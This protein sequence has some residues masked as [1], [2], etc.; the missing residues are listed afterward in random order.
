MYS[1]ALRRVV[2]CL[3]RTNPNERPTATG[4]LK[5]QDIISK[6]HHDE[7]HICRTGISN[8]ENAVMQTIIVPQN[9]RKLSVVLPKPCYPDIRPHS[10][11]AWT[12]QAQREHLPLV[13]DCKDTSKPLQ[14]IQQI[15]AP[16]ASVENEYLQNVNPQKPPLP[17][18][19]LRPCQPPSTAIHRQA[20]VRTFRRM[21]PNPP[22]AVAPG[23]NR[24]PVQSR[25]FW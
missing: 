9:L 23:Y 13:N 8:K 17:T 12:V 5:S 16:A 25:V 1:D 6:L 20:P 24:G 7:D 18:N 3:L 11:T 21:Q 22:P 14:P 15:Q 19:A 4:L 10:P 2:G